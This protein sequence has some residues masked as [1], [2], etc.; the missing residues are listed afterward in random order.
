MRPKALRFHLFH[1]AARLAHHARQLAVTLTSKRKSSHILA[2]ARE[3]L[4]AYVTRAQED[5]P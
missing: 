3:R 1:V 2:D 5:P 4:L